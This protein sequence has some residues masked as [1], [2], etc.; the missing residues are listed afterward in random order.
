MTPSLSDDESE[1]LAAAKRAAR[2]AGYRAQA[3]GDPRLGVRLAGVVLDAYP[4]PPGAIIGGYWPFRDEM[5]PRPLM[6]ALAGRG[7]GLALPVA[8]PR[9]TPLIFRRFAFGDVLARGPFATHHPSPLAEEV[10]PAV[11]L[12]PLVAFDAS[13]GR[14]GH[15]GGYY[16]RTLAALS[17]RGRPLALGIG[18]A[19]QRQPRLPLGPFDWPL[20]AVATEDGLVIPQ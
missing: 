15:G 4:L 6:L 12:V 10:T 20:D 8:G 17:E 1:A 5:D 11:L 18:Y 19:A 7:H 16:D 14:L 3:A 9:G 2:V 13:G